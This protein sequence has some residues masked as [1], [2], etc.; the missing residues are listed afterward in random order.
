M[1]QLDAVCVFHKGCMDGLASAHVVRKYL[2][3]IELAARSYGDPPPEV[4][5]RLVYIVDY[6]FTQEEMAKI[7]ELA[8]NVIWLDHHK[9]SVEESVALGWGTVDT[10][11]CG[12]TLTWKTI[13]P[14]KELPPILAYVKDRDLWQWQLENSREI[15]EALKEKFLSPN[16]EPFKKD[17]LAINPKDLVERGTKLVK[18]K[19]SRVATNCARGVEIM[20]EGHKTWTV[21]CYNDVSEVG[22]RI[23][24]KMGYAIA[25]IFWKDKATWIYSLRSK[26]VD[27]SQIAKKRGGGGHPGA[28]GFQSKNL[29]AE[30]NYLDE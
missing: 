11:E 19:A 30:I 4:E 1:S 24:E 9:T 22:E 28:A 17:L 27:V 29:I 10:E 25:L 26:T 15:S 18:L 16:A 23:Y 7:K 12:A 13:F 8:Q 2:P 3:D 20:F 21:N 5:G 14:D 6:S